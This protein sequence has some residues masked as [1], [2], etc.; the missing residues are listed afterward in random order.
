MLE[1]KQSE[2][3]A[4][5]RIWFFQLIN[6]APASEVPTG[7]KNNSNITY[8]VL[9]PPQYLT[10]NGQ[11]LIAGTDYTISGLTITMTTP[12][13]STDTFLSWYANAPLTG[14][15]GHGYLS[16]NGAAGVISVNTFT[17]IDAVNMPGSYY[18]QLT[19]G[20]VGM[21]GS[22]NLYVK[23][24]SST[25]FN[26]QAI[27]SY[28]DPYASQGGF[29]A[30]SNMTGTM[31]K[32]QSDD[33]LRKI[34]KMI[35]EEFTRYEEDED[36]EEIQEQKDYTEILNQIL[37][38][39]SSLDIPENNLTPVLQAISE[40]EKPKDYS[41]DFKGLQKSVSELA[42]VVAGFG[43][44]VE[45][46]EVKMGQAVSEIGQISQ[47]FIE[48]QSGFATLKTLM[49][50]FNSK[51][52]EVNNMDKRFENMTSVMQKQSLDDLLQVITGIKTQMDD[53]VKKIL[54]SIINKK[55]DILQELNK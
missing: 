42:P 41:K 30:P 18:L 46:F 21:L 38:L 55:Y 49:D 34:R 24:T 11:T 33:L 48:I 32:S 8:T 47:S 22:L 10:L 15:T 9:N 44:S 16:T 26:A 36:G 39:V 27:V 29:V 20:E 53:A 23:T 43:T 19:Q 50:D 7:L 5:K 28:N 13:L 52:V 4:T 45:A 54:I 12:P 40:I 35:T 31:T 1:F 17:E 6:I 2:Q 37:A 51:A 14:Q 25:A 3:T